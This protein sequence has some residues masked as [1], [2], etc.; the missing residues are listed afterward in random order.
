MLVEPEALEAR[1]DDPN[2]RVIDATWY[3]P[4]EGRNAR[5]EYAR[6]H[7]PGAIY[8]DLSTD[9]ANTSAPESW[10][11]ALHASASGRSIVWSCTTDSAASQPDGSGG[12]CAMRVT[13]AL[14]C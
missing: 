10:R 9:L 2:L 6:G 7:L 11:E 4:A 14:P 12:R 8:L 5:D 1:L 13:R 3:L